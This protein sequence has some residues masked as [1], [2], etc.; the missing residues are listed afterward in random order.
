MS[1][2]SWR[3]L[4]RGTGCILEMG[5]AAY[6]LGV[7]Q[8]DAQPAAGEAPPGPRGFR[9][10]SVDWRA[11]GWKKRAGQLIPWKDFNV[12]VDKIVLYCKQPKGGPRS[13]CL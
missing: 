7:D 9:S 12:N 5:N 10:L 4:S 6:S 8:G 1:R 3:E 2:I 13:A 11:G